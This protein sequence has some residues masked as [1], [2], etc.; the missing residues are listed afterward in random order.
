MTAIE[1][2]IRFLASLSE[3]ERRGRIDKIRAQCEALGT[4]EHYRRELIMCQNL[5]AE[6]AGT[7]E[8][9]DYIKAMLGMF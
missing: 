4:S 2:S 7:K 1:Y 9:R 3:E 6:Q 5:G 8:Y